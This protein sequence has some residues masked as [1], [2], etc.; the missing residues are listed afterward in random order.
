MGN[1]FRLTPQVGAAI[2][3]ADD[4]DYSTELA[5]AVGFVGSMQLSWVISSWLNITVTPEYY[6]PIHKSEMYESY[7]AYSDSFQNAIDGFDLQLGVSLIF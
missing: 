5:T 6:L 3:L 7:S 2:I 1:H 4:D